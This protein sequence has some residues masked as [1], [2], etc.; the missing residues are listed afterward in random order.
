MTAVAPSMFIG[1]GR[2][3]FCAVSWRSMPSAMRAKR[4][5]DDAGLLGLAHQREQAHRARIDA[6]P[7]M[8]E[9]GDDLAV[10]RREAIERRR[11]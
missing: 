11:R 6:V 8:A 5:R 4:P 9:A 1:I 3:P 7:A 10:R 2:P